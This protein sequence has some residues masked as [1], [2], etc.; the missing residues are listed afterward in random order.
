MILFAAGGHTL[1]SQRTKFN[2]SVFDMIRLAAGSRNPHNS[3]LAILM[4]NLEKNAL[5]AL[6][7]KQKLDS[8][9]CRTAV[10]CRQSVVRLSPDASQ[11]MLETPSR[12]RVKAANLASS[13]LKNG[14]RMTSTRSQSARYYRTKYHH[15][16]DNDPTDASLPAPRSAIRHFT[17]QMILVIFFLPRSDI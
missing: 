7:D 9:R 10:I 3:N 1:L 15:V 2:R 8:K 13:M 17:N 6:R 12:D 5:T 4:L 11:L 14:E 16:Y